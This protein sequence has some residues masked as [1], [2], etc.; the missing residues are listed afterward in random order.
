MGG[1]RFWCFRGHGVHHGGVTA[2]T[3]SKPDGQFTPDLCIYVWP[4]NRGVD[5]PVCESGV[6]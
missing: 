4:G 1:G 5:R 2:G 6:S 3:S